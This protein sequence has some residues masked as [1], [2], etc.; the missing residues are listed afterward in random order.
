MCSG[1]DQLGDVVSA[2]NGNPEAWSTFK[3][4]TRQNAVQGIES[5]LPD[6][7]AGD[8][9]GG[10]STCGGLMSDA[11]VF[12]FST[13][14]LAFQVHILNTIVPEKAI[15]TSAKR[16]SAAK[17][18]DCGTLDPEECLTFRTNMKTLMG[19]IENAE[20]FVDAL[21]ALMRLNHDITTGEAP[22]ASAIV[23][24]STCQ[25]RQMQLGEYTPAATRHFDFCAQ[26]NQEVLPLAGTDA[27]QLDR[28]SE[29]DLAA[30]DS[31]GIGGNTAQHGQLADIVRLLHTKLAQTKSYYNAALE[32]R[33]MELQGAL[34]RKGQQ[35]LTELV[36][37]ERVQEKQYVQCPH[38]FRMI[39]FGSFS[40]L[41]TV[42]PSFCAG[43]HD[44]ES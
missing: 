29:T 12:M 40:S 2:A 32:K 39:C 20:A 19:K 43:D 4:Q 8:L 14:F 21:P 25:S 7:G 27:L 13:F 36:Q 22:S 34:Q 37:R 5:Q 3:S 26:A 17:K 9:I 31:I 44:I 30:L 41:E 28:V 15:F 18:N 11:Q 24:I 33:D 35:R 23:R 42:R 1:L 38:T 6:L 10:A 16:L